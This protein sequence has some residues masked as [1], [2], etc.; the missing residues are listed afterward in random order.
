MSV[1]PPPRLVAVLDLMDGAVV[2]GIGGRR[3]EYRPVRS[4]ICE[5]PDPRRVARAFREHYGV[6]DLYVADLDAILGRGD[7]HRAIAELVDDGFRIAVDSGIREAVDADALL[8]LGVAA[9]IAG[10]ETLAGPEAL[11]TLVGRTG[12]DRLFFSLDL[13]EGNPL[14]S[15]AAWDEASWKPD[16]PLRIAQRVAA[17]G[18]ERLIV[19]DL[20]AVGS[21]QGPVT[22]GLCRQIREL[23][24]NVTLWTGGGVRGPLDLKCLSAAGVDGVLVASALHDRSLAIDAGFAIERREP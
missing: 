6:E 14:A 22:A 10:L 23:L 19:L 20:R 15:P 11:T 8:D 13:A 21:Q 12:P 17:A 5:S 3:Q 18:I 7:H 4:P 16:S 2:R 24:P 1:V 9:V